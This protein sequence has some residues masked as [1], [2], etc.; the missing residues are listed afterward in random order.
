MKYAFALAFA[1]VSL[2]LS[3][4]VVVPVGPP[5]GGAYAVAPAGVVVRPPVVVVRPYYRPWWR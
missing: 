3:G 4:C 2:T 5:G 1:L